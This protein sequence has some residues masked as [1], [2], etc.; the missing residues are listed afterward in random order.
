MFCQVGLINGFA[1]MIFCYEYGDQW[2]VESTI[3]GT[4]KMN[5]IFTGGFEEAR[6]RFVSL[7]EAA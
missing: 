3:T 7:V 6:N 4:L 2:I 5:H 1:E